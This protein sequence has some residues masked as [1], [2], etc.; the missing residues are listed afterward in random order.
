MVVDDRLLRVATS[1][2]SDRSMGLDSE[3]DLAVEAKA[4]SD[5]EQVPKDFRTQLLAEHLGI[6]SEKVAQALKREASLITD[7]DLPGVE[8][9]PWAAGHSWETW[10]EPLPVSALPETP[11]QPGLWDDP[12]A[13][14][15]SGGPGAA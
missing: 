1:N 2:L 15:G 11:P 4:C 10:P 12:L 9:P 6:A 5:T 8:S 14:A 7:T 13:G 3:C